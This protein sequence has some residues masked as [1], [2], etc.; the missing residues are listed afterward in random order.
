MNYWIIGGVL[1]IA[2]GIIYAKNIP[3]RCYP[4]RFDYCGQSH[5]IFHILIVIAAFI[6]LKASYVMYI[7]RFK[8]QCPLTVD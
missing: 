4:K 5:Q 7:D 1:Y 3:E 6:H 8:K 2:G